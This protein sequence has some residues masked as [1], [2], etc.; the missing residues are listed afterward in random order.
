MVNPR[1]KFLKNTAK[2]GAIAATTGVVMNAC[3][4]KSSAS[5]KN[6]TY[7]KVKKEEVLYQKSKYWDAYYKV[8][9]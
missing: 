2:V 9:Y 6:L 1:R 4:T 3:S 8:A 5:D 7:G